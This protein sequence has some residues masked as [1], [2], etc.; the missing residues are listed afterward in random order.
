VEK[1]NKVKLE[2]VPSDVQVLETLP[3]DIVGTYD[4]WSVSNENTDTFIGEIE[5]DQSR[6]QTAPNS[7]PKGHSRNEDQETRLMTVGELARHYRLKPSA[8]YAFIKTDS[9]F[10]YLNV[11]LKK[12]Y[13]IDVVKY[14][15]W[16]RNRT[17]VEKQ[18][19]SGVPNINDLLL[20]RRGK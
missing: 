19:R 11:G 18:K 9:S 16:V 15:A 3:L 12:K 8:I 1:S 5:S 4:T 17:Q 2:T 10:P 14:E 20:L 13:L 7:V 6:T